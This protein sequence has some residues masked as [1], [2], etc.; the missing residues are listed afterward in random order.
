MSWKHSTREAN[1]SSLGIE[2]GFIYCIRKC[3]Y[4]PP[5]SRRSVKKEKEQNDNINIIILM[6]TADWMYF[7]HADK[8]ETLIIS[9]LFL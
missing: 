3:P 1:V 9:Y 8:H 6:K 4:V 7:I 2:S 5:Q